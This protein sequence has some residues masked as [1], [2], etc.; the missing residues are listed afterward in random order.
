MVCFFDF[1]EM[2]ELTRNTHNPV[3][4]RLESVQDAQS[5]SAYVVSL[6]DF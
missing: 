3:I 1:Q 6:K 4:E 2:K 5:E